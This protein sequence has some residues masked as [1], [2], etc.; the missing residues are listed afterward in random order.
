VRVDLTPLLNNIKS[1]APVSPDTHGSAGLLLGGARRAAPLKAL[2]FSLLRRSLWISS[3]Y[4]T[5]APQLLHASPPTRA[6]S[7]TQD[8]P[9]SPSPHAPHTHEHSSEGS[10]A[11][12]SRTLGLINS[13]P[14]L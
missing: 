7:H 12:E 4:Y 9:A 2:C 14:P 3:L 5:H 10:R 13:C 11:S 1:S 8:A 6:F